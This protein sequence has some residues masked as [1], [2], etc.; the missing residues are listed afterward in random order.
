MPAIHATS[1][2]RRRSEHRTSNC[3]TPSSNTWS[4]RPRNADVEETLDRFDELWRA[5][6]DESISAGEKNSDATSAAHATRPARSRTT[7][8]TASLESVG[9]VSGLVVSGAAK[10]P[11][12]PPEPDTRVAYCKATFYAGDYDDAVD[13][14]PLLGALDGVLWAGVVTLVVNFVSFW[15]RPAWRTRFGS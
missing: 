14:V 4:S 13:A 11:F 12:F 1:S 9:P 7:D 2:A 8:E 3:S 5:A 15:A 6:A 10:A